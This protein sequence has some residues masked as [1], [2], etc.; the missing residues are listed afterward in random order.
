MKRTIQASVGSR[1]LVLEE[2]AWSALD[3]Y[4]KRLRSVLIDRDESLESLSDVE[5]RIADYLW[6][7][8][9]AGGQVVRVEDVERAIALM[10]EP[11]EMVP[12]REHASYQGRVAQRKLFRDGQHRTIGGVCSGLSYYFG[13]DV[14]VV[15]LIFAGALLVLGAT[16]WIYIILW[17]V[18]PGTKTYADRLAMKGLPITAENLRREA[19]GA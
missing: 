2:D 4:L 16:F 6:E 5:M 14:V 1:L 15:R 13:I 10:G 12:P 8:R 7:W 18:I 17:I 3:R 11:D 19:E 9:A